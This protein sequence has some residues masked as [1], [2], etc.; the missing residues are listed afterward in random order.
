MSSLFRYRVRGRAGLRVRDDVGLLR[1][2]VPTATCARVLRHSYLI[3]VGFELHQ[4]V[5]LVVV[6]ARSPKESTEVANRVPR[7]SLPRKDLALTL[8]H[9]RDVIARDQGPTAC[10][11]SLPSTAQF[12]PETTKRTQ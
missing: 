6:V 7:L 8:N 10:R 1:L 9:A 4:D 3:Q 11:L 2:P 5:R 12:I